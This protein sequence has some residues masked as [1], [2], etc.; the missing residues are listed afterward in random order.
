[1][2][3]VIPGFLC[4]Q[5]PLGVGD[6]VRASPQSICVPGRKGMVEPKTGAESGLVASEC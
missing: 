3:A 2:D 6:T 1:M 4:A 5:V